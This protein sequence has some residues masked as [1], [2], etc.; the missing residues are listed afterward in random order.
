MINKKENMW[1]ECLSVRTFGISVYK[2]SVSVTSVRGVSFYYCLLN[3]QKCKV[4]HDTTSQRNC[5][6]AVYL[7]IGGHLLIAMYDAEN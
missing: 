2:A 5:L 6:V 4:I 1:A 7:D 3:K